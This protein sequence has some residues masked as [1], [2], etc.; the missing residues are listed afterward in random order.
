MAIFIHFCEMFIYVWPSVSLFQLFHVLRW[1][2]QGSNLIDTHYFQLWAKGSIAYITPISPGK[3]DRWREDWVIVR[4]NVHDRLV[5]PT[6]FSTAKRSDWEEALKLHR[7][8]G[9]MIERIKL[10]MSHGL[11][12][13]MVLHDFLTR[14]IAP[15]Q[16]RAHPTWMY[17]GKGETTWLERDSDSDLAPDVLGALLGRLSPD[18]CSVNF[19]TPSVI[20]APMCSDQAAWTRLPRELPT[21]DDI[22]ITARQKGDVSIVS[23]FLGQS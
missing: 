9:P 19:I 2:R 21:L 20:C 6:E 18:P 12:V 16:D 15:L 5:L 17:T 22:G 7:A 13:M 23:R 1:S 4:A 14:C 10:L 11:T 3:W 8:Y